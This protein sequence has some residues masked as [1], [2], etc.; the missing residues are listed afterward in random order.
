LKDT[1]RFLA[2][3]KAFPALAALDD[4]SVTIG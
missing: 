3:G 4:A 2:F 1:G